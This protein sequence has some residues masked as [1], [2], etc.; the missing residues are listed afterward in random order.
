MNA[1]VRTPF[2]MWVAAF[3]LAMSPTHALAQATPTS[4]SGPTIGLALSGGGAKG[5]A[6]IGVLRVLEREGIHIDVVAGTSM[7]GVIGGLYAMGTSVDSI[8]SLVG[9]PDWGTILVD[10]VDR[11]RRFLHQRRFDERTVLTLPLENGKV[12]LPS[13][14]I[15]GSNI[16]RLLEQATWPAA[17]TRNFLDL[18]RPFVAVATDIETGDAITLSG[19][20]LAEVM[21]ASAGVPGALEPFEIDGRLLVDGAFSRNLPA[22][23]AR[24]L[25]ADVVICSDVSDP[26]ASAEELGSF[27]DVLNQVLTLSMVDAAAE[28]R[29]LC[30]VLIRPDIEG[31]STFGFDQFAEW[32]DRGVAAAEDA[33]ADLGS[34]PPGAA[35]DRPKPTT[36]LGDSVRIARVD[37]RSCCRAQIP[38]FVE[39]ELRL[40]PGDYV[41]A[42]DL[43]SRLSDIEAADLFGLVRYRLDAEPANE[44]V[45]LTIDVQERARDRLGVGLRYDDERRAA[46]LFTT[47][48]HN[49]VRYGSVTRL[50]LRVGEETRI[51]GTYLRRYGVTGR[52]E[53]GSSASWSQAPIMLAGPEAGAAEFQVAEFSTFLGLVAGRTLFLGVEVS[54]E[55]ASADVDSIPTLGILS[56]SAVFDHETL[57]RIDFP[58]SG[59]D[60]TAQWE[61]GITDAQ[62]R[63]GFSVASLDA[64]L[65]IPVSDRWSL[66]ADVFVGV[67]NGAELPVHRRF[68]MGGA[69]PT[70]VF[71]RTQPVFHGIAPQELGGG[72]VQ[73]ARLE[74]RWGF[75]DDLN[76][77][78]HT[79]VGGTMDAWTFPVQDPL[80]SWAFSGGWRS[81]VGPV[82]L[83]VA[84]VSDRSGARVSLS[85]GRRF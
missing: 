66:E 5:L 59:V 73:V 1:P 48:R 62:G 50:D 30:D 11:D 65:F 6:H 23:D 76:I 60:M 29:A 82:R 25:G 51:G 14:A 40:H 64:R 4:S 77:G 63:G 52:F 57:D 28:Q 53:G 24:A 69:H 7:G 72:A 16:Y 80:L 54:G 10:E 42:H 18:P 56:I 17:T 35:V 20:V 13:G 61:W 44:G 74:L 83:E 27:I 3:A 9:S 38:K 67:A 49:L 43:G 81:L 71:A 22:S 21:R 79:D 78:V 12:T 84:K 41:G 15:V 19:G 68:Y 46:L 55:R 36:F 70:A 34:L 47:T 85:V 39:G 33:V 32:V 75:A 37:V 31:L 2:S 8:E 58:H 26:L 45:V